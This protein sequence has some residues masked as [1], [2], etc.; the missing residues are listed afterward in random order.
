MSMCNLGS[1]SNRAADILQSLAKGA[2]SYTMSGQDIIGGSESDPDEYYGK[3][4][5]FNGIFDPLTIVSL[6]A[7]VAQFINGLRV[8]LNPHPNNEQIVQ[9]IAKNFQTNSFVA[10]VNSG[11][12][13]AV[14]PKRDQSD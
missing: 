10:L 8:F 4:V 9:E 2:T 3:P 13:S 1:G 6:G 7:S 11:H 14:L 12:I 5:Q